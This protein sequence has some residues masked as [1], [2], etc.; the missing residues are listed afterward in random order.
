MGVKVSDPDSPGIDNL[1]RYLISIY[2][3]DSDSLTQDLV[4]PDE[5]VTDDLVA[6]VASID[7]IDHELPLAQEELLNDDNETKAQYFLSSD[8]SPFYKAETL[9]TGLYD[10]AITDPVYAQIAVGLAAAGLDERAELI[11]LSKIFQP[12][13]AGRCLPENRKGIF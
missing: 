7:F 13:G 2:G 1:A 8:L 12:S 3:L 11:A 5:V 6:F 9:F 4:V 10:D